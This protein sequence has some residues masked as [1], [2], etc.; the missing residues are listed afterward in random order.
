[1]A[2]SFAVF[3]A[4]PAALPVWEPNS[5]ARERSP[6]I[7]DKSSALAEPAIATTSAAGA[8]ASA[9]ISAGASTAVTSAPSL[10]S[11]NLMISTGHAS[12]AS[13]ISSP[14]SAPN[15]PARGALPVFRSNVPS[16]LTAARILEVSSVTSNTSGAISWHASHVIQSSS[17]QT[18]ATTVMH[19]HLGDV[20]PY[21][22]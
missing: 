16:V 9:A 20:M 13:R 4:N 14:Y 21:P 6:S 2:A 7:I 5:I 10:T 1:M 15:S 17:I 12:D 22:P 3:S 8:T 19:N 11:S 18:F